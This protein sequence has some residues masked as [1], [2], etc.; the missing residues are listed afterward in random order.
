MPKPKNVLRKIVFHDILGRLVKS[1]SAF[2]KS[3]LLVFSRHKKSTKMNLRLPLHLVLKGI[4]SLRIAKGYI[5]HI[6]VVYFKFLTY[7]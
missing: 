2:Y 4:L 7:L 6:H 1:S 3:A 5:P